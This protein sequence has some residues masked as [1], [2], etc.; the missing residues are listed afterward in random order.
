MREFSSL[1]ASKEGETA[2]V[3]IGMEVVTGMV[4]QELVEREAA[5]VML[6]MEVLRTRHGTQEPVRQ[7]SLLA[8]GEEEEA[9]TMG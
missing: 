3:E 9:I 8:T 7:R 2:N 6:G 1:C 5:F 4:E